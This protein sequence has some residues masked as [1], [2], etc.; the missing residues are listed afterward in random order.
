MSVRGVAVVLACVVLA[1]S[2]TSRSGKDPLPDGGAGGEAPQAGGAGEESSEHGGAGGESSQEGGAGGSLGATTG[3]ATGVG[4]SATGGNSGAANAG[5]A[6]TGEAGASGEASGSGG[7]A[8]S[9]AGIAGGGAAGVAGSNAGAG[10]GGAAGADG[11]GGTRARLAIDELLTRCPTE[12]ELQSVD[13]DFDLVFTNVTLSGEIVCEAA[14]GSRD[15]TQQ[16]VRAYLAFLA[17]RALTFDAPLPWTYMSLYEWFESSISAVYFQDSGASCCNVGPN[18]GYAINIPLAPT[19]SLFGTN[20]WVND[21]GNGMSALIDVMVHETRHANAYGHGC[22]DGT[23]DRTYAEQG[24][25]ATVYDFHT[26]LAY[27]ADPCF[28]RPT[29]PADPVHRG[30]LFDAN[31]YQLSSLGKADRTA[32][33]RF[34]DA[35]PPF[36]DPVGLPPPT[37]Q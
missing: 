16:E 3:G 30:Q 5:E 10:G 14:Q 18:G 15:L 20:L 26:W 2:G 29:L 17:I 36:T 1:C 24:A 8:G 11:S 4:A 21:L 35:P 32:E 23:S 28:L 37:C 12:A 9:T 25:W 27:H 6:G 19:H 33:V 7:A 22:A 34:C 13:D 31:A